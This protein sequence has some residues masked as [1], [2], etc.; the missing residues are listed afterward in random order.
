[1]ICRVL[2]TGTSSSSLATRSRI[3]KKTKTRDIHH[4]RGAMEGGDGGEDDI[5]DMIFLKRERVRC[6]RCGVGFL[7]QWRR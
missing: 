6:G 5:R 7:V 2:R 3:C 1:M 4:N